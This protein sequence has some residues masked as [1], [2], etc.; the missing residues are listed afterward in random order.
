[1]GQGH[2]V[3]SGD[4]LNGLRRVLHPIIIIIWISDRWDGW[5]ERG[6]PGRGEG[7]SI[8]CITAASVK[9]A[10]MIRFE[11]ISGFVG[12]F[13]SPCLVFNYYAYNKFSVLLHR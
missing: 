3:I 13:L 9:S 1:M 12:G 5:M 8:N 10:I 7:N 4:H 6:F 11:C 2:S